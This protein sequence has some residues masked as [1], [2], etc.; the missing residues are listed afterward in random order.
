LE[1]AWK[2]PVCNEEVVN[3]KMI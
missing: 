2:D 3:R 1:K